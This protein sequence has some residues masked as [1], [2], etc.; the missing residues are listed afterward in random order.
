[1][2]DMVEKEKKD[3]YVWQVD[4]LHKKKHHLVEMKRETGVEIGKARM[5]KFIVK[6]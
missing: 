4:K 6:K 1:M 2:Q 5:T 3:A